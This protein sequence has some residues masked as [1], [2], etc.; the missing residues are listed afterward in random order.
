MLLVITITD[1]IASMTFNITIVVISSC[2]VI[3]AN[4]TTL[5]FHL[6][7]LTVPFLYSGE[8]TLLPPSLLLTVRTNT[9]PIPHLCLQSNTTIEIKNSLT[10]HS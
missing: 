6:F 7:T 8:D 3:I 2:T 4:M 5:I 1:I 10:E 9:P